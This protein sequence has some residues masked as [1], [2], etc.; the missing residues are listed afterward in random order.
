MA[1]DEAMTVNDTSDIGVNR[2]Y[3]AVNG[4][5]LQQVFACMVSD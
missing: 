5:G 2:D 1:F 4:I 3:T